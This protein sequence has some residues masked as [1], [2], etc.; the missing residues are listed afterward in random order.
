MPA[1][2]QALH[3]IMPDRGLLQRLRI[4][5]RSTACRGAPSPCV[6]GKPQV[7]CWTRAQS[8]L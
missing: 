2:A 7:R 5:G 1:Q 4:K 3:H 6:M 8:A